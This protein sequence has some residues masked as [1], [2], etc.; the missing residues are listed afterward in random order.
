VLLG[1]SHTRGCADKIKDHLNKN[2][3][4]TGFVQPGS[5]ILTLTASAKGAIEEVTKNDVLVFWGGTNDVGKSN[6]KEWLKHVQ[7]FL[8]SNNHTNIILISI[9]HRHDLAEWSCVNKAVKTFNRKLGN[10]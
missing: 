7:N 2:F 6:T 9:P 1:D 10:S 4:V 8:T 5:D 3:N